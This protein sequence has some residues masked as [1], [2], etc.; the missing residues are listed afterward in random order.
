M[1]QYALDAFLHRLLPTH[2]ELA[3]NAL[4]Q[5]QP[6]QYPQA[7]IIAGAGALIASVILYTIGIWLRRLPQKIS[8]APQQERI[9]KLRAVAKEWLPWVLILSPTPVGGVLVIAAGF[10]NI[11]PW[12]AALAILAGEIAWRAAPLL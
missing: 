4:K 8:T 10:F 9:E 3:L 1:I 5:F 2:H 12:L 11:R 7:A 6:D